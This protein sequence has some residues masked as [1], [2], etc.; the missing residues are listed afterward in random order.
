MLISRMWRHTCL[1]Y[2][3]YLENTFHFSLF[4]KYFSRIRLHFLN[5][6]YD[7]PLFIK[8]G[9][10]LYDCDEIIYI[11]MRKSVLESF[12]LPLILICIG[13]GIEIISFLAF[14]GLWITDNNWVCGSACEI[15]PGIMT[16]QV[17]IEICIA[18]NR[19]YRPLYWIGIG[20]LTVGTTF[21]I[22]NRSRSKRKL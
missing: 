21:I 14:H 7:L 1:A 5:V 8:S 15:W 20:F 17:C 11:I 18:R 4:F 13:I 16:S 6:R 22:V 10:V 12:F 2:R 3:C 9:L 19:W